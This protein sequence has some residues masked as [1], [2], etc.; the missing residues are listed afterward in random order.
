MG[1]RRPIILYLW[2]LLGFYGNIILVRGASKLGGFLM[3][4]L[5]LITVLSVLAQGSILGND[6]PFDYKPIDTRKKSEDCGCMINCGRMLKKGYQ[7][8]NENLDYM[9][10]YKGMK[11]TIVVLAPFVV[12][13]GHYFGLDPLKEVGKSLLNT[14]GR[15]QAY[16][17][18]QVKIGQTQQTLGEITEQPWN[19]FCV[20]AVELFKSMGKKLKIPYIM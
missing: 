9:L 6:L 12:L 19:M 4:R 8:F 15:A 14:V 1:V 7:F 5:I 16:Y 20:A 13:Y 18:L 17:Y 2:T 3:K 11:K 10:T